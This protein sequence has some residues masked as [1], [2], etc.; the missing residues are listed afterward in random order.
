MKQNQFNKE[1]TKLEMLFKQLTE[2]QLYNVGQMIYNEEA[3]R[4]GGVPR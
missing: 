4:R 3:D 1:K 2:T